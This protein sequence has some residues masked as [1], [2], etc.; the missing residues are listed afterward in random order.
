MCDVLAHPDLVKLTGRRAAA[1]AEFHDRMAEAAASS[2]MAAEVS[3]A[4]WRRP[5]GEA[6]PSPDLLGR[7][8]AAG[9]PIT[10]AS[11]AHTVDLV[12]DATDA[13]Q[14]FAR[15]VGYTTVTSFTAR[16]GR[17]VPLG[18]ASS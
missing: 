10:L 1:P 17:Q 16:A 7:F 8:L 2:G 12:A 9:V 11:D 3:S 15:E 5:V 4:G 13:L 18:A 14:S 6:Y